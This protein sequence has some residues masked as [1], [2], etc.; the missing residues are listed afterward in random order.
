MWIT[1][2]TVS[3]RGKHIGGAL[4]KLHLLLPIKTVLPAVMAWQPPVAANCQ[5]YFPAG[6]K[7]VFDNLTSCLA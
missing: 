1:F 6:A 4:E 5:K 2:E 7:K 3:W